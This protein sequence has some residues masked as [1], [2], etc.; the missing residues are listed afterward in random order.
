MLGPVKSALSAMA[1]TWSRRKDED[2][3]TTETSKV[4]L[5]P[6]SVTTIQEAQKRPK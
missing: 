1:Y 2:T 3:E 4:T 6:K 5:A